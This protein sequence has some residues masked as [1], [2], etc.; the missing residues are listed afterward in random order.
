M[1]NMLNCIRLKSGEKKFI[2]GVVVAALMFCVIGALADSKTEPSV[3]MVPL[4]MVWMC[5]VTCLII[6]AIVWIIFIVL[7]VFKEVKPGSDP[8][9]LL[10]RFFVWLKTDDRK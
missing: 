4:V 5:I 3:L 2:I 1:K 6:H 9:P 7:D 10:G 8:N